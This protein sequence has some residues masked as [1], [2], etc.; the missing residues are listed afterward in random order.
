MHV[1]TIAT[2]ICKALNLD[3]DLAWAVSMGHDLGHTPFGHA[4]EGIIEK[5]LEGKGG[6]KHE[7]YS[8]RVVD[9]LHG[10]GKGMNL[11]YAVRDGIITHCGEK[12]EQAIVPDFTVKNLSAISDREHY[13]A[14][15]EGAVVRMSD[16]IAYLGRDLEDAARLGIISLD[17]LPQ[18]VV[19]VL[20]KRNSDIIDRLVRDVVEIAE[21]TGRIGFSDQ[22][23]EAMLLLKRFNYEKIYTDPRLRQYTPFFSRIL[24]TL[25]DYLTNILA[26]IGFDFDGYGGENNMLAEGFGDYLKKM[27]GFYREEGAAD[28]AVIFDYIAGMTDDY[29]LDCI[30]AIMIP[31][32]EN[33]TKV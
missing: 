11:T 20:G 21:Q 33:Y 29:A 3:T 16:K 4:G 23:F 28:D 22:V 8:L 5:M 13:P 30:S 31:P 18:E 32:V 25:A 15:W 26:R 24:H 14:T 12:F 9:K 10:Y 17:M 2:T 6:F 19:E 7:V 27:E 1:A